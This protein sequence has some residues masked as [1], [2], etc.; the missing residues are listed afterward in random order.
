M[1][2]GILEQQYGILERQWDVRRKVVNA[3]SS[4]EVS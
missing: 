3:E 1:Q 2:C 4:L